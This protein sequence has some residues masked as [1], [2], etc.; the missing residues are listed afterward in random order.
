MNRNI[1]VLNKEKP[2]TISILAYGTNKT[3]LQTISPF[4]SCSTSQFLY[5][6]L[7]LVQIP[8]C[9][10]SLPV[11]L[12]VLSS[13]NLPCISIHNSL[14]PQATF[15]KSSTATLC[16]SSRSSC[17]TLNDLFFSSIT[18]NSATTCL[19]SSFISRVRFT[20]SCQ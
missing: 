5:H 9:S 4:F 11:Y 8:L 6:P 15:P 16:L 2:S 13:H 3:R 7:P 20:S 12:E 18:P 19:Y 1:L 10:I 14:F 17:C